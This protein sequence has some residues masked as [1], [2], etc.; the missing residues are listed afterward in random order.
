MAFIGKWHMGNDPT[1]RPGFDFWVALPGQGRTVDPML[2]EDG[3]RQQVEPY[4]ESIRSPLLVR[5]PGRIPAG[6]R[7]DGLPLSIDVAP[8]LLDIGGAQIGDHVQGRSLVPLL[9]GRA[10]GD[11]P[12]RAGAWRDAVLIEFY[13]YENPMSWLVDM[14]YRAVRTRRYKYVHWVDH[15]DELYDVAAD[16][17]ETRNLIREPGMAAV[18]AELRAELGRLTLEAMGL[19]N[20]G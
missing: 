11:D 1:P 3:A 2:F 13:T 12:A 5:W 7:I 17:Y 9:A 19:A 15:E 10:A 20:G 16:R 14:A 4:D 6:A 8:T 18:A